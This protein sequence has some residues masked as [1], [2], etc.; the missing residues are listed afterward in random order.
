MSE[1]IDL[2]YVWD[3]TITKILNYDLKSDMGIK[4]KE[5]V[6]FDKLQNFNSLMNYID[7]DFTPRGNLCYINERG[8]ELPTTTLQECYNLRWFIRHLID[9]NGYEYGGHEN[10]NPLSESNW[11]YQSNENLMKYVIFNLQKMT[12]EQL[13]MD[14]FKP[15]I[16]INPNQQLDTNEGESNKD[17][18]ESTTSSEISAQDS[19]S[20]TITADTEES[21][22]T[23][24]LQ[25]HNVSSKAI[26][27]E[28]DSSEDISVIEIE[29]P[30]VMGSNRLEKMT[31]SLLPTLKL[32][33]KT[34]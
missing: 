28:N 1:T 24:T 3:H 27:H 25:I 16:K 23:E 2:R 17:E 33:W 30:N 14:P 11:I 15:I 12:P 4:R 26:H 8:E 34:K 32:K 22:P 20:D 13:K 10:F 5:W 9:Q 21:K 18:E 7:Q 31:N 29:P 6:V 19:G